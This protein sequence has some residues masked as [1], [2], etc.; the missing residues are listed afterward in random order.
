MTTTSIAEIPSRCRCGYR[1]DE[2]RRL[3]RGESEC[4]MCTKPA[5]AVTEVV[6]GEQIGQ[7]ME[8]TM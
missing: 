3:S 4:P 8:G 5:S 2:P 7:A 1:W 6:G